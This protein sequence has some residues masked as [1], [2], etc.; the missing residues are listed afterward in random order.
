MVEVRL[1]TWS[2]YWRG[3]DPTTSTSDRDMTTQL[4]RVP[5][6]VDEKHNGLGDL[7]YSSAGPR[8]ASSVK[9]VPD[10]LILQ[11]QERQKNRN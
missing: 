5:A 2:E 3:S 10:G 8:L 7:L 4:V 1:H 11:Q 9:S 6:C